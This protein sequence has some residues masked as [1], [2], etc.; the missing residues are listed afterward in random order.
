M[1]NLLSI[2]LSVLE[3]MILLQKPLH[4]WRAGKNSTNPKSTRIVRVK[5]PVLAYPKRIK[6]EKDPI[7]L[8][9]N[10]ITYS[11]SNFNGDQ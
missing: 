7:L 3:P 10:V 6:I 1:K 4:L 9:C 2:H 11:R 5:N 8:N